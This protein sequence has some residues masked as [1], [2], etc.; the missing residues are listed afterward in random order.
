MQKEKKITKKVKSSILKLNKTNLRHRFTPSDVPWQEDYKELLTGDLKPINSGFLD[1]LGAELIEYAHTTEGPLRVEWFF[2]AR[3]IPYTT[4]RHWAEKFDNFKESYHT[5]KY[6]LGMRREDGAIKKQFDRESVF[7][8]L[9]LYDPEFIEV[10]HFHAKMKAE[11][12]ANIPE[13]QVIVL[14][15]LF[16][17]KKEQS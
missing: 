9:H 4:A 11:V 12:L 1:R 3:R 7:K 13:R 17:E 16:E 8:S 6:I 5:A 14:D 2:I 15:K 10:A